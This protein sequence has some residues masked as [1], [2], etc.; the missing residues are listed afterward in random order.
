MTDQIGMDKEALKKLGVVAIGPG[1]AHLQDTI[2][3]YRC[4]FCKKPQNDSMV[5]MKSGDRILKFACLE[6]PG[7]VQEFLRQYKVPPLGWSYGPI[8][9]TH[10]DKHAVRDNNGS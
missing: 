3:E 10:G 2:L 1:E 7:V 4:A 9:D 8:G 6:H 5:L